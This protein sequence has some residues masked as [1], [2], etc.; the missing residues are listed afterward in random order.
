MLPGFHK[1]ENSTTH[2]SNEIEEETPATPEASTIDTA[3]TIDNRSN[4]K[5]EKEGNDI[6]LNTIETITKNEIFLNNVLHGRD[7]N[8]QI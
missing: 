1:K 2:N 6:H 8:S 5:A 3:S 7:S 4:G